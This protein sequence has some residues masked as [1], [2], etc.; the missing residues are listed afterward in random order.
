MGGWQGPRRWQLG[1][2][3][4]RPLA[5]HSAPFIVADS[6]DGRTRQPVSMRCESRA[7]KVRIHRGAHEVGGNCV[8][9]EHDG[10]RLVLDLGWPLG[11]EPDVDL[12]L[13]TVTGLADGD[14]PSLLG[15]LLS[16]PHFDHY[17]LLAKVPRGVPVYLGE[18][19]CRIL[20][21]A[22]F[23][24]GMGLT[25]DAAG[26]L[27]HREA[28]ALGPFRITPYLNDHS[29]FDAYSL[30]VEAGS[31]RLFYTGDLRAHGRKAGLFEELLRRP[32]QNVDVLLMEGTHVRADTDGTERAP[33]ESDVENAC[34]AT[35]RATEGM[36]LALYSP[37]NV[38]RLV[39]MYKAA[40]RA[41]RIFVMDLYTAAVVAAT[42][43]ITIPQADWDRVRVYL[44]NSQRAKVIKEQAFERTDAVRSARIFPE[45]MAAR[46]AELV[47]TF[48]MSMARELESATCF[49][50]AS[51]VWS[52]WPGYLR[53]P[54]GKA[55]SAFLDR[56][57]IP[58]Q[59]HHASGHAFIPDL[60]RLVEALAPQRLVPIHTFAGDRFAQ[61]FPRVQREPDGVWWEV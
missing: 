24:T 53:E 44:P 10:A 37:Q 59:I 60:Q 30:L 42:G 34:V 22:A 20:R 7:V 15:V 61:F 27:R 3:P 52:M 54:S 4:M 16:H 17:G 26:F 1:S 13:P 41:D 2:P 45:E 49:A 29:A 38:D 33:S 39:T 50:G 58:L 46:R 57:G 6:K 19:A 11:V 9:I 31:R 14:D 18:A 35:F 47:M 8:E 40:I 51:A 5:R 48:R 28:F 55:L 21:E 56:H 43:R 25:I 36:V 23:F 32:P 12:A